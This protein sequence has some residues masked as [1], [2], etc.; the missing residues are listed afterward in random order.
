MGLR[1]IGEDLSLPYVRRAVEWLKDRQNEDGGW[2]EECL[3]YWDR[4]KAGKGESTPSQTAW[5]VLGLLAAEEEPSPAVMRG[6]TYLLSHQETGGS[7]SEALFTG[8]GFP[9]HFYLRYYGYCNYFPLM[10]LGQFR[11]RVRALARNG[12]TKEFGELTLGGTPL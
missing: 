12:K 1:A 10:A 7:W 9:Q 11:T 8:T 4:S 2:G 3:S 6:I 5:A